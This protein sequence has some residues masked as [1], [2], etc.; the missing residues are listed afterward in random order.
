M[1]VLELDD[2]HLIRNVDVWIAAWPDHRAFETD[3][4]KESV[5]SVEED[6]SLLFILADGEGPHGRN[7]CATERGIFSL[8]DE[9]VDMAECGLESWG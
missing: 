2:H 5:H 9:N 1:A 8:E 6:A 3:G 4:E 7:P